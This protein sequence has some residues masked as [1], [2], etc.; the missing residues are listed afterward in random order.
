MIV[1]ALSAAY[2]SAAT[3][4][5][6]WYARPG[7]ARRL[8]R[9]VISLGN[10]SVG[11]SGKTPA[12]AAVARLLLAQDEQPV[13]LSRGYGRRVQSPGVTVVSDRSAVRADLAHAG[14]EP[15]LLARQLPGVPVLV[16]ADRYEAGREAESAHG[17]TVHILDD[18][19]QHV[20]LA[21]QVD[22]LLLSA[23]DLDDRVL[24]AG[25]LRE[26]IANAGLAHAA[27]VPDAT[28]DEATTLAL[29][30]GLTTAFAAQRVLGAPTRVE[31]A[32]ASLTPGAPVLA[33]AGIARPERFFDDLARAGHTV[34]RTRTFPDHHAFSASDVAQ[35]IA[36]AMSAGA[37][38]IVTTEKDAVRLE[39]LV[40]SDMPF[41]A[42]PLTLRVEPADAFG[43]WLSARL[44]SARQ[45]RG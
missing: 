2:G 1:Q 31:H 10:L 21:R 5:R 38:A 7:R 23:R 14:D 39:G 35:V 12:A 26:P 34:V 18:G 20:R 29:R 43:A 32:A 9:P 25:R 6:R 11:G 37:V 19:F 45:E 36:D 24:P 30:A 40:G 15:L 17:A 3:L 41:Y 13:I 8:A 44:A 33:L 4:R 16:C 27:I 28:P 22:L 42:V